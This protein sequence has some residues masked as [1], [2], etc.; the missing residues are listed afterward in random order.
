MRIRTRNE[1]FKAIMLI[2]SVGVSLSLVIYLFTVRFAP[3]ASFLVNF[4]IAFIVSVCITVPVAILMGQANYRISLMNDRNEALAADAETARARFEHFALISSDWM[5]ETNQEGEL[6]YSAGSAEPDRARDTAFGKPVPLVAALAL[7]EQRRAE[8]IVRMAARERISLNAVRVVQPGRQ[9]AILELTAAPIFDAEG[10][11]VGYRGGGRDV[12]ARHRAVHKI[13]EMANRDSLTGALNQRAF[14]DH[15]QDV[16]WSPDD[17][18]MRA[19]VLI[20]LDG[21][22]AI[23][24]MYGHET[25][26]RLLCLAYR[27]I[28][29][30][31]RD[32]DMLFRLGG[33]EFAIWLDGLPPEGEAIDGLV[34]RLAH[35]FSRP[36]KIGEAKVTLGVSVGVAV[37]NANSPHGKALYDHADIAM[38]KAKS[39]GGAQ[40]R[41][42][43]SSEAEALERRRH[44]EKDLKV[45]LDENL[46]SLVYQPQ[47]DID[48]LGVVGF[49]AL[50]RWHHHEL[51][52]ISP[53]EFIPIA[54]RA[55]L[56]PKLGRLVMLN[57]LN[58]ALLWP[59]CP[60]TGLLPRVSVNLSASV[61]FDDQ[62]ATTIETALASAGVDGER[63]EI[64]ITESVLLQRKDTTMENMRRLRAA[65]VS[66]AIDDFGTGFSSLSYLTQFPVQSLKIDQSF[67]ADM[68]N[69]PSHTVTRS[70]VQLTRN[71][72]L[73]AVAEGVET[74]QHLE[75]LRELGCDFAQGYLFAKPLQPMELPGFIAEGVHLPEGPSKLQVAG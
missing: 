73:K 59:K 53:G 57:A 45:A 51:G 19:L 49:E 32:A 13:R 41:N 12:T 58:H 61:L 3:P 50:A 38:Y 68:E 54:E 29:H 39:E 34:R 71:L 11:F 2:A 70:I 7:D 55:G 4:S 63:L 27:R 28:N 47:L 40:F 64:E 10:T 5:F 74:V 36:F 26:D 15:M 25:G 37:L 23:N 24:D 42:F 21:F 46:L 31:V 9:A 67:I 30:T 20:D 56:M 62:L 44:L 22:K 14:R 43:D 1:A 33:D 66:F 18:V 17:P 16:V 65:G 75:M 8:F 48:T 72:N 35:E 6:T 60:R 52:N 69:A